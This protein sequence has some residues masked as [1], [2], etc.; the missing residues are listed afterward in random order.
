MGKDG[1]YDQTCGHRQI[2]SNWLLL[3]QERNDTGENNYINGDISSSENSDNSK[4]KM[5]KNDSI[6]KRAV[7]KARHACSEDDA[8]AKETDVYGNLLG[9]YDKSGND[10]RKPRS[11]S[12]PRTISSFFTMASQAKKSRSSDVEDNCAIVINSDNQNNIKSR[13]NGKHEHSKGDLLDASSQVTNELNVIDYQ[14]TCPPSPPPLSG[15]GKGKLEKHRTVSMAAAEGQVKSRSRLPPA[16]R[17]SKAQRKARAQAKI[18]PYKLEL[19][20]YVK[21]SIEEKNQHRWQRCDQSLMSN[22][23]SNPGVMTSLSSSKEIPSTK[24]MKRRGR[25]S[26]P[27]PLL[28]GQQLLSAT[29]FFRPKPP[30]EEKQEQYQRQNRNDKTCHRSTAKNEIKYSAST[31]FPGENNSR[32]CETENRGPREPSTGNLCSLPVSKYNFYK[33]PVA[34]P[35]HLM[36]PPAHRQETNMKRAVLLDL[37]DSNPQKVNCNRERET[38]SSRLSLSRQRRQLKSKKTRPGIDNIAHPIPTRTD[39]A[40]DDIKKNQFSN[41]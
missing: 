23:I 28:K 11:K 34:V 15:T 3:P 29:G 30:Q 2:I 18:A 8:M 5:N 14:A 26:Q 36:D 17:W 20:R 35:Q 39:N 21:E 38:S 27:Q 10:A 1:F 19:W 22:E 37:H 16:S 7:K 12:P 9:G 41:D 13:K 31:Y 33:S 32:L 40:K 4:R 6:E 24:S 25:G